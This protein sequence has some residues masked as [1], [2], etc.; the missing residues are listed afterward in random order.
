MDDKQRI[1][2]RARALRELIAIA[3]E[4]ERIIDAA[5]LSNELENLR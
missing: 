3:L 5:T 4:Q 1:R 2:L